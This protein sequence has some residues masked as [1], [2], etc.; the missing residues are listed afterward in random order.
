MKMKLKEVQTRLK[1]LAALGQKTFPSK[2][3]FAVSYNIEK[4][5]SEAERI[6]KERRKLCEQYAEKDDDEKPVM[7][8]SV[9][10]GNTVKEYKMDEEDL[11]AFNEE[12]E[13][14]LETEVDIEIRTVK[15]EVIEQCEKVNR[16]DIP[17]VAELLVMSFM[18]KE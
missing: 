4:F 13:S 16:Y 7:V 14:L 15:A 11:K 6:E 9:I 5:Q 2:L 17:T 18:L 3:S 1:G 12:Y 10:N 8:D